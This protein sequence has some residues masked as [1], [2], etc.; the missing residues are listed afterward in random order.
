V[1]D[2]TF[3]ISNHDKRVDPILKD[4]DEWFQCNGD[5]EGQMAMLICDLFLKAHDLDLDP[6]RIEEEAMKRAE[7]VLAHQPDSDERTK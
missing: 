3:I 1:S 4:Y 5:V 7:R 6:Q 2:D